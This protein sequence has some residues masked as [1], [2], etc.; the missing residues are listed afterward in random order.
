MTYTFRTL[1]KDQLVYNSSACI[2]VG[3]QLAAHQTETNV[4]CSLCRECV[5]SRDL[6]GKPGLRLPPPIPIAT[7][8]QNQMETMRQVEAD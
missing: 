7:L 5:A 6:H 1:R 3:K 2:A 4:S 8:I